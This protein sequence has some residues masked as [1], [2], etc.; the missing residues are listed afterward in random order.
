MNNINKTLGIVTTTLVA[1]TTLQSSAP[2]QTSDALLKKL[3]EKGIMTP[4]EA[5]ELAKEAEQNFT[6]SY[7][8]KSGMMD[9]VKA[10]KFN[11]DFRPR[12]EGQWSDNEE[13]VQ[14]DRFRY[15][16]RLAV[17]V[18]VHDNFEIG[19]RLTSGDAAT[20]F[21]TGN[22]LS[23][24]T[25]F[26]DNG[27]RKGVFLDMAYAKW[28]PLHGPDLSGNLTLGKMENPFAFTQVVFDPDYMPE[29]VAAQLAYKLNDNH[30]LKLVGGGFSLD[31]LSLSARDPYLVGAQLLW[32]AKW[33]E[34]W[35]S[36]LGVAVL[37]I[38]S[39]ETLTTAA[40]PDINRGNNRL[41]G[42]NGPAVSFSPVI[43]D[44]SLT[45]NLD[46]FPG[47]KGHFPIKVS[48][49]YL[50][51]PEA[52]TKNSAF[53]VGITVGKA[54]KKRLWEISYQY[55]YIEADSWFEELPDDDFNGFY[56]N[57]RTYR[58]GTNLRGHVIKASYSPFD[59]LTL[60]VLLYDGRLIDNANANDS[61]SHADHIL[62]DAVWKF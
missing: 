29:G 53:A 48:G 15:R 8:A 22:P 61:T 47:Y 40:V 20:G 34:Q 19:A 51:N 54:G 33:T 4:K 6:K 56:V 9:W 2:A 11:G 59:S 13:A 39:Q 35:Q 21:S 27:S 14:R 50:H 60:N 23:G 43:A 28:S 7:Q 3:V 49:E 42:T 17:T 16:L 10:F 25:R 31:E 46:S 62:V 24:S 44:A 26:Q 41:G 32:D 36:S 57:G 58:G 45:Y 55:R 5:E 37:A 12:Y 38:T 30:S 52:D 1:Y 18:A